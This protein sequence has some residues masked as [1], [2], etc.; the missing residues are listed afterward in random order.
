MLVFLINITVKIVLT[1]PQAQL[2][3]VI[4]S[5]YIILIVVLVRTSCVVTSVL[6]VSGVNLEVVHTPGT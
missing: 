1:L 6:P 4:A 3:Y 5:I 2:R